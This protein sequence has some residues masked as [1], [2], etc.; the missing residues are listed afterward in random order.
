MTVD[1]GRLTQNIPAA[2]HLEV[3]IVADASSTADL[4]LAYDASIFGS[5]LQI[6]SGGEDGS[7]RRRHRLARRR[8]AF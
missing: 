5:G 8:T 7:R 3:W 1:F 4:V 6:D 2:Q